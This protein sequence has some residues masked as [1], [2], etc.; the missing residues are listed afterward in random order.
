[1]NRYIKA[2]E[3]GLANEENGISYFDLVYELHGSKEKC[4][5]EGAEITFYSW[6]KNNFELG[7]VDHELFSG[8]SKGQFQDFLRKNDNDGKYHID[9]YYPEFYRILNDKWFLNGTAAKQYLD[10]LELKE[11]RIAAS[12][13]QKSSLKANEKANISIKVAIVTIVIS[14]LLGL[15]PLFKKSKTPKPPFEVK[16]IED[17]TR[18]DELKK[19]VQDLKEKLYKAEIMISSFEANN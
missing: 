6:F 2:M 17:K 9:G 18:N 19:E 1:M 11:S 10:Y 12:E 15:I 16:I 13:A 14:V 3:I 7:T 5:S 4:F 8:T